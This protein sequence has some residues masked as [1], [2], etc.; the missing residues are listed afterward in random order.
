MA[1]MPKELIDVANKADE[2]I[3]GGE[4]P[5]G[6]KKE[7]KEP[8]EGKPNEKPGADDE[9]GVQ[10]LMDMLGIS[11]DLAE[12]LVEAGKSFPATSGMDPKQLGSWLKRSY[13][14]FANLSMTIKGK[15]P[16]GGEMEE[17]ITT[18]NPMA[19][20]GPKGGKG[21]GSEPGAGPAPMM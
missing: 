17:E 12:N 8:D 18:W 11:E 13:D 2:I 10:V 6:E 15:T 21:P 5:E 14:N 9:G 19:S 7:V 3:A 1:E 4:K 20:Y 16:E